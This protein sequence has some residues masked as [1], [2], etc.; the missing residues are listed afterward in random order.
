MNNRRLKLS[1]NFIRTLLSLPE[2]GL[3]YQIVRVFL[4]S[5][6]VL[7]HRKV[8]H[9]ELL[10]L[11]KNEDITLNDITGIELEPRSSGYAI[12]W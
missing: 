7:Y 10:M 5:G 2:S 4:K 11:E 3:G 1:E 6:K 12:G 8:L 9:S